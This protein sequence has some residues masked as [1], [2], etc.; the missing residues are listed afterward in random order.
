MK[1]RK[2]TGK[3]PW[4]MLL[5][6][7]REKTGKSYTAAQFSASDQ[8][9]RTF[10][11]EVGEGTADQYGTI[12]GVRY[13]IVEHDGTYDGTLQAVKDAVA[14]PCT[15][16]PHCVVLD[17]ATEL[18]DLLCAEQQSEAMRRKKTVV[19]IDQWN[20]AKKR[21]K[22]VIDTLR[23]HRGPVVLTA[24]YE[25]V[26]VMDKKGNPTADKQW[27]VRAEKNLPFEVDGIIE[28][29][30]YRG[31]YLKGMRSLKFDIPAGDHLPLPTDFTLDWFMRQLDVDG[32]ARSYTALHEDPNAYDND[33]RETASDAMETINRHTRPVDEPGETDAETVV[34]ES[35]T[36]EMITGPQLKKLHALLRDVG[37]GTKE[38]RDEAILFYHDVTSDKTIESSPDLTKFQA[39]KVIDALE[40]MAMAQQSGQLIP[41]GDPS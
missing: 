31:Y 41:E 13:E 37:W 24:R 7:G 29:L 8:V 14:V 21:W 35:G 11:I 23:D 2:P 4:P 18:W 19:T 33:K 20:V 12:P 28:M 36:V 26:T 16:K 17:S 25:E 10:W 15:G 22:T 9:D 39:M 40:Q 38:S 34:A 5:L 32:G 3:V 1:T 27:K 6:A 30:T